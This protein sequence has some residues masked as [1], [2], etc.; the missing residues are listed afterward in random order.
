MA[1]DYK[2]L[3]V[4]KRAHEL[5]LQIYKITK[6]FPND[7]RFGLTQQIRRSTSSIELNIAEGTVGSDKRFLNYL[8]IALGSC[9]ETECCLLLCK[10]LK[11]I[12][13]SDYNEIIQKMGILLSLLQNLIK[14]IK[15]N[16]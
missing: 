9:K 5:T 14:T 7:E 15:K 1:Q 3:I 10:E 11:Y 4:W 8:T 13:D 2:K 6:N 16:N 12:R